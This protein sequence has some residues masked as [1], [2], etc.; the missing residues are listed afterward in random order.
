MRLDGQEPV[1]LVRFAAGLDGDET[2]AEPCGDRGIS[3]SGE[4]K[5]AIAVTDAGNGSDDGGGSGAEGF[6]E[7]SRGGGGG[8]FVDGGLA[9]FGGDAHLAKQSQSGVAR[10]A[11]QDCSAGRRSDRFA[12]QNK[13][14]VHDAGFFDVAALDSV[15]PEDVV[16]AFFLGEAR[17]EEATGV[18][19]GGFA[20]SGAAGEGANE[21]LFGEEANRLR[22]I[23]TDGRSHDDEAETIGRANEKSVV[24]T[25]VGW[26][27]VERTAF[28]MR[29]PIAI[30][31]NQFGDAFEEERLSKFGH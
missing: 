21:T 29:D 14:Y 25:K 27:N 22:E 17:G 15:Q 26:A 18:V 3:D 8:D 24:D 19:A 28:T 6:G 16:K 11:G 5:F 4:L 20:V 30:E 10:N 1:V 7:F 31:A 13:E 12:V 23:G 9:V 2:R